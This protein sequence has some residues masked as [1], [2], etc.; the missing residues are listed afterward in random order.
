MATIGTLLNL[1]CAVLLPQ[2]PPP[3][4][5]VE[6]SSTRN[7]PW[8]HRR[9]RGCSG[10]AGGLLL[11][12]GLLAGSPARS[13]DNAEAQNAPTASG[14]GPLDMQIV[15]ETLAIE[16]GPGGQENRQWEP[17]GRLSAGDELHYTLRVTNPGTLA[18]TDVV[19]TKRLPFG[20]HDIRGSAVGPACAVQFSSDGGATFS[21]PAQLATG[22]GGKRA[23]RKVVPG[24]YTHVRWIFGKPLASK[25]TA[26]LRF[27]ATFN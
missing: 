17:A 21:P 27:R 10:L 25:A 13:Q 19:V 26:L 22:S 5:Y 23:S 11:A 16:P 14:S 18:V 12:A 4:R 20:F 8:R 7:R 1:A 6:R 15:V 2:S 3:M 9:V 24:D